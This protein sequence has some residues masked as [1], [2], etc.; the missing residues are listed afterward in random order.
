MD[1]DAVH[2][3]QPHSGIRVNVIT[4]EIHFHKNHSL[5]ISQDHEGNDQSVK[6]Y[7]F[8]KSYEDQRFTKYAGIFTDSTNA[9]LA[10]L[11]TAIPPPIQE[12]PVTSA[13]A[14]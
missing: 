10:A 6:A 4:D 13:A 5:E 8:C 7:T 1:D 11:A 14:R 3:C 9:A 12:S 2:T